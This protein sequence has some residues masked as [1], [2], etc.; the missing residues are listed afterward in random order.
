MFFIEGWVPVSEVTLEVFRRLQALQAEGKIG[1]GHGSLKTILG[2]SVWEV[3][4]GATKIGA[5]NPDGTVVDATPDLV[6][7]ADPTA[8]MNEHID[9]RI[10][11]VGSSRLAREDGSIPEATEQALTYGPFFNLPVVIPLNSYQSSLG[12]LGEEVKDDAT[13]DTDLLDGARLILSMVDKGELV[14]R[15][16]VRSKI[17]TSLSRRRFKMAWAIAA[18]KVPELKKP[19]RWKG[20]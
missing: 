8:L 11:T 16:L 5:T 18:A 9:L 14:T 6:S 17:G 19:N 13:E 20:L 2:V 4:D 15:E 3:L 12:Y 7:W 1:K 10:G